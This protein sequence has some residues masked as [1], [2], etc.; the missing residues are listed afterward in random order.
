VSER[1]EVGAEAADRFL[2][3]LPMAVVMLDEA[4]RINRWNS[5]AEILYGHAPHD[6]IGL[7][8]VDVLFEDDDRAAVRTLLDEVTFE[9]PWEG[10]FR[11][12][13]RDGALLVSS[14]RV[15]RVP[16]IGWAWI[17][18]DGIDQGL[19]E[20][21]RS[22][23]MSAERAARSMAEEALGLVEAI[24]LSAPVGI[25][26]FDLE[27]R[28]VRVN[29]AY[30]ALSGAPAADHVGGRLGEVVPLP[31]DVVADVRRVVTTG[32]TILGR[33]VRLDVS[34]DPADDRHFTVNYFPVHAAGGALIG[35]GLTLV[36]I[37]D[38]KR[39]EAERAALLQRAEAAQQRLAILA[40]ASSVL[41]TTMELDELLGRLTRVLTPTAA[42]WCIIEL[43]SPAG[44]IEQVAVSH[45]D[46]RAADELAA[47]LRSAPVAVDG[48]GP[49]AEVVRTGRA[50]LVSDAAAGDLI[51]RAALDR[52]QADMA[53][54][55]PLRSSAI[56][57]I[58]ARGHVMGVLILSTEGDRVLE[59]DDLDLAVEVAHRTALAV[60][61]ARAYQQEHQI[62]ESLQR[63]LLPAVVPSVAGLDIAVRYV[64][65]TD[66]ASVGGDWYDVLAF[67]D[68]TTGIVVGDVVGHDIGASTSM[69]QL[70]SA[71]RAYAYEEHV[72]PAAALARVDRLF[73]SLGLAYATCIFG[74]LD[75]NGSTFRWSN[76]GHPPPLL[77]RR[78]E[79]SFL[80]GGVGVLLGVTAGA[81]AHE[82]ATELQDGDLL[83]LYTDG[84]V[85]RRGEP[86]DTGLG[87]LAA[88]AAAADPS[89]AEEVCDA[90]LDAL[91]PASSTRDDDVAILVARVRPMGPAPETRRLPFDP[92]PESAAM[93]R[94]F[95]AGV[96]QSAGLGAQLDTAVLLAS[97]LVT[98]A[99]R[100]ATGPCTLIVGIHEDVV[101]VSVEDGDPRMPAARQASLDDED[102]RGLLLVDALADDWGF[103]A[104]PA[105]KATWFT[106]RLRG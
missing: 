89:D 87:R 34:A 37:T 71:L 97:E 40:T 73:E 95:L 104:L 14:F 90:L 65:A 83:V 56:V 75:V 67:D 24:L 103:R 85:E 66:G 23:L 13:R 35:A 45:R 52:G 55:F 31:T 38:A 62:A 54:Q 33:Q 76:A 88:V 79:A 51:R 43:I 80:T 82:A 41:T 60:T 42:A 2:D 29:D 96:L 11:V 3:A 63:A 105:G 1:V 5:A 47:F 27:L 21:E 77:I 17:A 48:E 59:D 50:R 36:E 20:Q 94:G 106:I 9:A 61:N 91:V 57:P 16:E 6:V 30:A 15:A 8:L 98:N 58:E 70:R 32:R 28:Y 92:R 22:V 99:V 74:V 4:R 19:A 78:G 64:A 18:T 12:R 81:S 86:L 7:P 93:A 68:G 69:G 46:R 26:V 25:A 102:G 44:K 49:I 39:A 101:E 84:L 10:D 53:T 100:H 72:A